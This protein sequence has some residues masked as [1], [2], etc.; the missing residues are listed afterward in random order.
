WSYFFLKSS[1][2]KWGSDSSARS[3]S[4]SNVPVLHVAKIHPE[5]NI[6]SVVHGP[7]L[8]QITSGVIITRF[9]QPV[10]LWILDDDQSQMVGMKRKGTRFGWNEH[11]E[12]PDCLSGA[13]LTLAEGIGCP[14]NDRR[15]DGVVLTHKTYYTGEEQFASSCEGD[16]G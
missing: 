2:A 8:V 6:Y 7:T 16:D 5:F 4:R 1:S 12:P 15:T 3:S 9:V 13:T 11:D 14:E 10:C